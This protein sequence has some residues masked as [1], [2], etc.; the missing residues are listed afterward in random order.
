MNLTGQ[1]TRPRGRQV[2]VDPAIE[3]EIMRMHRGRPPMS[4]RQIAEVLASRGVTAPRSGNR[5]SHATVA[6][7][8]KRVK[9][10]E[11]AG[12]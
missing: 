4:S 6:K 10:R 5:F 12:Q 2:S 9:A 1:P 8:I 7:I 11:A 3:A